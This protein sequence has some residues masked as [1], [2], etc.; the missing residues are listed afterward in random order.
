VLVDI[1]A[2][3]I[4]SGPDSV[5]RLFCVNPTVV[6]AGRGRT[7]VRSEAPSLSSSP[8][9]LENK[10]YLLKCARKNMRNLIKECMFGNLILDGV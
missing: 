8:S 10:I 6:G 1:G 2:R 9:R 3:I 4:L 7:Q 5:E